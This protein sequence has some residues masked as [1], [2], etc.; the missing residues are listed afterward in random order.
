M[1]KP[2]HAH[3]RL[4]VCLL[5]GCIFADPIYGQKTPDINKILPIFIE[6]A[7]MDSEYILNNYTHEELET[8][9]Q[10]KNGVI[11]EIE[12]KKYLVARQDGMLKKKLLSI[13]GIEIPDSQFENKKESITIS[14][15][16]FKRYIFEVRGR[17]AINGEKCWI[18]FFKPKPNFPEEE[19]KYRV[20]NNLGG[21]AW[22]TQDSLTFKKLVTRRPREVDYYYPNLGFGLKAKK[23]EGI[24]EASLLDNRWIITKIRVEFQYS[25]KAFFWP[26]NKHEIVTILY[27]NYQR[28]KP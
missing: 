27:Q 26:I 13:N 20:I 14:G 6:K 11:T 12:T 9:H 25:A 5:S 3:I 15:H 22:V 17:G 10:V 19:K 18:L 24:V 21:E 7:E 8:T 4:V 2:R 16:L 1:E 28:R 23:M